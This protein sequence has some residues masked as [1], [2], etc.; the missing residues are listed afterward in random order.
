LTSIIPKKRILISRFFAAALLV[1][2]F[3][4]ASAHEGSF[5]A[6]LLLILGI[7]LIGT[8]VVGRLWC[9][10]Y[11]CGYKNA[12]LVTWGPYSV[13]RNPLYLFSMIGVAGVGFTTETVSYAVALVLVFLVAYQ[14]VMASEEKFLASRFGAAFEDYCRTTP[15]L[16]PRFGGFR[17]PESWNAN[18][19]LYRRGVLDSIWFVLI[20]GVVEL[21]KATHEYGL[22]VPFI[23]LP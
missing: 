10:F 7:S 13:T 14:P 17:E 4:T 3:A 18:P 20:I 5:T 8:A 2:M 6:D 16:F 22:I 19:R 12:E 11:I 23:R 21:I 1:S 9:S 15:R